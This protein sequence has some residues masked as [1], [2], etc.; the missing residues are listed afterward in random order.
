MLWLFELLKCLDCTYAYCSAFCQ[1]T[2]KRKTLLIKKWNTISQKPLTFVMCPLLVRNEI[3]KINNTRCYP[4]LIFC[5]V[6]K[7]WEREKSENEKKKRK[8][9]CM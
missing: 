9:G 5:L 4:S 2:F 7:W 3:T 1:N 6:C 8:F